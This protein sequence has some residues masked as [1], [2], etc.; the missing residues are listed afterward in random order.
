[1]KIETKIWKKNL[2]EK[3]KTKTLVNTQDLHSVPPRRRTKKKSK[4]MF[5]ANPALSG[6]S[7][8]Y[9]LNVMLRES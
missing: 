8:P 9:L 1:M 2:E 7:P 5:S 4:G 6:L 3:L